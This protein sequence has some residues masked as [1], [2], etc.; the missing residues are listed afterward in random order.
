MKNQVS[1]LALLLSVIIITSMSCDS[2]RKSKSID[3]A[4]LSSEVQVNHSQVPI[5]YRIYLENSGSVRG[6]FKG[7]SGAKVVLTQ[8]TD[9]LE[10]NFIKGDTISYNYISNKILPYT[11]SRDSFLKDTY[12]RCNAQY[13]KLDENLNMVMDNLDENSVGFLI[14]DYCFDSDGGNWS[15]AQ[16]GITKLFTKRLNENSD[17][18][19]A[20]LKYN[21]DFDGKYFPGGIKCQKMLPIYVWAFGSSE[22][23]KRIVN[24]KVDNDGILVFQ[25]FY[26]LRPKLTYVSDKPAK[27]HYIENEAVVVKEWERNRK[28]FYSLKFEINAN[29]LALSEILLKDISAYNIT[30]RYQIEEINYKNGICNMVISTEKPW[31][32]TIDIDYPYQL[33]QWIDNSNFEGNGLPDDGTT[34][35]FKYLVQGVFDA[36][37]NKYENYFSTSITLK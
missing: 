20:I 3:D 17:L 21:V 26:N 34:L 7:T 24:L 28:G 9:R 19:I 16:S 1:R 15:T 36:Y 8:L 12:N 30:D 31:P 13:S 27:G 37:N 5:H 2:P 22:S 18:T 35:G 6:F 11:N 4:N 32:G 33:P 25:S 14:S 29:P 10:E 23:I